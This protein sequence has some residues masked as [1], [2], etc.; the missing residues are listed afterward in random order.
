[1]PSGEVGVFLLVCRPISSNSLAWFWVGRVDPGKKIVSFY[2]RVIGAV[3][4]KSLNIRD[5]FSLDRI[6]KD[7]DVI[8]KYSPDF[9]YC[10]ALSA[11]LVAQ[12]LK[13]NGR[14]LP[15]EGVI[16]T[17]D[18]LF[19]HYWDTIK[20]AFCRDVFN[21]YGCNDGGARGQSVLNTVFFTMISN[22]L[23]W[24]LTKTGKCL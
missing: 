22:A 13:R 18:T 14:T 19:C 10:Y 1:M 20:E 15:L 24:S 21:N 12:Y 2:S 17:S 5:A 9:A 11:F 3:T 23:S 8:E 16:T 4:E 6:E 7:L